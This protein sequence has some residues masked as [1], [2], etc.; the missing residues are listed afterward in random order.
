MSKK[1]KGKELLKKMKPCV[2]PEELREER[3]EHVRSVLER[4]G[5]SQEEI[6]EILGE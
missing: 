2:I 4:R 1:C 6:D 3:V 5:R